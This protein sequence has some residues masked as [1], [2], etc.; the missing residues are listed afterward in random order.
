MNNNMYNEID[1][2]TNFKGNNNYQGNLK[3]TNPL[4]GYLKGNIF[5]DLYDGYKN[6]S[7]PKLKFNSTKEEML[8]NINE[9][10]FYSHDLNLYLD[11]YPND[12]N[13]LDLYKKYSNMTNALI[14]EYESKYGPIEVSGSSSNIPF[15]W[16]SSFP[17]EDKN[18]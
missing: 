1:Y 7:I 15:N 11:N 13:A 6:I 2:F 17:W 18:V 3:L 16:V 9:M 12:K 10:S 5:E 8:F 14:K 4:N